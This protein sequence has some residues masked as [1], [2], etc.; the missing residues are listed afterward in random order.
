MQE[1]VPTSYGRLFGTYAEALSRDWWRVSKCF[2]R[3]K[4]VN[5]GGG[6]IGTGLS[7]P[8]FFI[9][10]VIQELQKLTGFPITRAENLQESTSNLD[11]LVE[12]HAIMKSHAVNL[13]KI[14][15]DIR[16]L[17][18]DI[19]GTKEIEIPKKQ[20]GSS[21]MPGKINPVI[22]EFVVS[23]AHKVY[24]NDNIITNLSALGCLELNA[25]IPTIGHAVIESL[26]LLIAADDSLSR[27]LFS[28]IIVN[29]QVSEERLFCSPVITTALIPYIGYNKASEIAKEMKA[30]GCSVFDANR[31]L[32]TI[33]GEKL[34]L[35][36]TPQN[37]LKLGFSL[38]D[39]E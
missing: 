35:L 24:A 9:M 4:T 30:F 10:E 26:K 6:A 16:L 20:V 8:R 17:A 22:P 28:G 12:V 18:S 29:H 34:K 27:H 19:G 15:S 13:E 25:Y 14:V 39:L 31:K 32:N 38:S 36:L 7:T 33:D 2:E 23:V 3:I 37:L 5:I 1:A 11:A 21:I